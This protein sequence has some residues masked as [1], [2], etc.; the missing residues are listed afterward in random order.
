ML[1][2]SLTLAERPFY[3]FVPV[4]LWLVSHLGDNTLDG[5]NS[6]DHPPLPFEI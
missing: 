5:V 3:F 4:K 2:F 6:W 1:K